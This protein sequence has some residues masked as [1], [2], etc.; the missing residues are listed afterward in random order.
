MRKVSICFLTFMLGIPI[1]GYAEGGKKMGRISGKKIVMVIAKQNFRD[2]EF[3]VP[4]GILEKD[5][6]EVI[7]ASSSLATSTGMFGASATPEVLVSDVKAENIDAV[8]FVGGSGASEYWNDKTS[9]ELIKKMNDLGK[10]VAAICIAP[11]TLANAG[12]LRGKKT[13]VWKS[14]AG[15]LEAKGASC[16]GK[17]VEID[18]NI[19]TADGPGSAEEFARAIASAL[20]E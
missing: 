16:T 15:K 10:V 1:S 19:I 6:A 5:G 9:H 18:G 13:T 20:S 14:E 3:Q 12:I 2:E 7:V 17:T 8:I 4:K 11:V